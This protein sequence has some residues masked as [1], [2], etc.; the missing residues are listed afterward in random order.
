MKKVVL[1]FSCIVL[2]TMSVVA[3]SSYRTMTNEA[4]QRGEKLGYRIH[5]GFIDAVNAS[6]EITP[7]KNNL[8]DEIPYTL[9]AQGHPEEPLIS[10]S[11]YAIGMNRISMKKL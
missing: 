3:Q 4:F 7:E 1:L 5:Y 8:T 10:F 6:I 11:K 9:W 2:S